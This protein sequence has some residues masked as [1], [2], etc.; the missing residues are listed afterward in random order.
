MSAQTGAKKRPAARA[1]KVEAAQRVCRLGHVQP[2][3]ADASDGC[4]AHTGPFACGAPMREEGAKQAETKAAPTDARAREERLDRICERIRNGSSV[5][6]ACWREGVDPDAIRG[7]CRTQPAEKAKIEAARAEAED[8][9]REQLK[10]LVAAG[11]PTAGATWMLE[12]LHRGQ[13]H[14]PTRVLSGQDP[15]AGPVQVEAAPLTEEA[16]R[17]RLEAV[18]A[19]LGEP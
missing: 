1:A 15:E 14:L 7:R 8:A 18:R 6:A 12:R 9:R 11:M 10:E 13:Y 5:D 16:L 3:G 17:K 4:Q 2:P 19:K